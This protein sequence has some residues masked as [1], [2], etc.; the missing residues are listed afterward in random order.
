M[1]R[2]ILVPA[3]LA[4]LT[5]GILSGCDLL[6][7]KTQTTTTTGQASPTAQEESV[8]ANAIEI[9]NFT[10][11]P[12]TITVKAGETITITNRDVA[13]HSYTSDDGT[14]F[15]TGILGKDQ[16][17]TITAPTTPGSYPV[18]CTPHPNITGTL[19]VE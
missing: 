16:S 12:A 2:K 11:S 14:S 9:K 7:G 5:G 4:I 15:D 1:T 17:K 3:A 6:K 13:G 10:F 19:V 8:S 18:H